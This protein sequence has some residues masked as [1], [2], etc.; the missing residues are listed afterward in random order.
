[1]VF[2]GEI[3]VKRVV[4]RGALMVVFSRRKTCHFL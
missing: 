4:K 3:V 2:C 1:V